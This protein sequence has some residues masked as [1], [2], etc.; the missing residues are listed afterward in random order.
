[1]AIADFDRECPVIVELDVD[2]R[3][4]GVGK[5]GANFE[6]I[7]KLAHVERKRI[8]GGVGEGVERRLLAKLGHRIVEGTIHLLLHPPHFRE[9]IP[10]C[11]RGR[12]AAE[13]RRGV[14][15]GRGRCG[16]VRLGGLIAIN[17][18]SD[19][20]GKADDK[21]DQTDDKRFHEP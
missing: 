6:T 4:F 10:L 14:G 11:G 12:P 5:G 15:W 7:L 2:V 17:H 8:A 3:G 16:M 18:E 9:R 19:A 1:M 20:G 13:S 21:R